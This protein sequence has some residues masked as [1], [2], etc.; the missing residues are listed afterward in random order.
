MLDAESLPW[1]QA[2]GAISPYESVYSKVPDTT[3]YIFGSAGS[4]PKLKMM[5]VLESNSID[6]A[7]VNGGETHQTHPSHLPDTRKPLRPALCGKS[8]S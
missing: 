6:I 2:A 3:M 4:S 1:K 8:A 7:L 5:S